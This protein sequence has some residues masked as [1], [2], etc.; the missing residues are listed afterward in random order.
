MGRNYIKMR[1]T[2]DRERR[3]ERAKEVLGT[4]TDSE[5]VDKALEHLVESEENLEDVKSEISPELGDRLS[6]SVLSVNMYPQ[7]NSK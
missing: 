4:T 3:L 6:T 1:A 7:V 2:S 5:A